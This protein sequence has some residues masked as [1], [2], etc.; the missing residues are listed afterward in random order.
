VIDAVADWCWETAVPGVAVHP[1][2]DGHELGDAAT[3]IPGLILG[4]STLVVLIGA[5]RAMRAIRTFI[6]RHAIGE[7]PGASLVISGRE[8]LM[9]SAGL[10]RPRVLI[11]AGALLQLDDDELAAGLAHEEGHIARRHGFLLLFAEACRGAGRFVPGTRRAVRELGL[12]LERDADRWAIERHHAPEALAAA[13]YKAGGV[14][15]RGPMYAA[16]DG[17]SI[18]ERVGQLLE[19]DGGAPQSKAAHRATRLLAG[20]MLVLSLTVSAAMPVAAVG[21]VR[22]LSRDHVAPSYCEH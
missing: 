17:G 20:T 18:V 21:A 19:G 4:G 15:P 22:E 9:G 3:V 12:H 6:A 13:I 16:L 10:T 1:G 8:I 14:Q 7:G 5:L 11:S 2:L